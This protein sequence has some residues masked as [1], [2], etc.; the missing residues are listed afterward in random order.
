MPNGLVGASALNSIASMLCAVCGCS[1]VVNTCW[2]L[3][4]N[5]GYRQFYELNLVSFES[6]LS[7][8]S[9]SVFRWYAVSTI[10][11]NF[12]VIL[13]HFLH[14][15]QSTVSEYI[16]R[17]PPCSQQLEQASCPWPGYPWRHCATTP[18]PEGMPCR[19]TLPSTKGRCEV[20]DVIS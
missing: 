19:W 12:S 16:T 18:A 11:E 3:Y 2:F 1:D 10:L 6:L 17:R 7:S 14:V 15:V 5:I 13:C 8:L 20:R 4:E 9:E